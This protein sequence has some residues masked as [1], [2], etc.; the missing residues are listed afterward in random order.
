MSICLLVCPSI[1]RLPFCQ[2]VI[3]FHLM[4]QSL[5]LSFLLLSWLPFMSTCHLARLSL[6]HAA[7]LPVCHPVHPSIVLSCCLSVCRLL[8]SFCYSPSYLSFLSFLT[9]CLPAVL[10]FYLCVMPL[11]CLSVIQSIRQLLCL[12]FCQSVVCSHLSVVPPTVPVLSVALLPKSMSSCCLAC[13][14]FCHAACLSVCHP[15]HPSIGPSVVCSHL[16]LKSL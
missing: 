6:C 7:C 4:L 8:P 11:V 12:A 10:S 13:P 15:F 1:C 2:S 3:C 14:S 9:V 16:K 5:Y